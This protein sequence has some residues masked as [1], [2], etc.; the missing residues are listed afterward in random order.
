M[1]K[2]LTEE[3]VSD[4]MHDAAAIL[5]S[6]NIEELLK[7]QLEAIVEQRV[8][9]EVSKVNAANKQVEAEQ[10]VQPQVQPDTFLTHWR[11]DINP[12][13]SLA[14]RT[15]VDG[16]PYKPK[17]FVL[18]AQGKVWEDPDPLSGQWIHFRR[19]HFFSKHKYEDD[20][21]EW[22]MDNPSIDPTSNPGFPSVIGGNPAI[23]KDDGKILG[24]CPYCEEPFIPGSNALKAHLRATHGV[25]DF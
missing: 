13:M 17:K 12:N 11:C 14:L 5:S 10:R 1:A 8:S 18:T 3:T 6:L 9:A 16:Q 20:F 4:P 2:P 24:R 25:T 19:G 15:I 22:K 7:G 23:Y 21:L